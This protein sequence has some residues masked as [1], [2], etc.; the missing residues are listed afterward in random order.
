M[1]TTWT[2]RVAAPF[3]IAA[4][5]VACS[6]EE[7]KR[8][9][10]QNAADSKYH[11]VSLKGCVEEAPGSK[12]FVLRQVQIEPV[13]MQRPDAPGA[14]GLTVTDGSWVRLRDESD[15]L[16]PHLGKIVSVSGTIIDDGRNTIGT[17][18]KATDPDETEPPV[19]KSRAAKD[20]HHASKVTKEAGPIGRVSQS[21]GSVPE[22]S[23]DRVTA[24]GEACKNAAPKAVQR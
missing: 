22:M 14:H 13:S 16:K 21:N 3:A 20:E 2:V 17:S 12:Q 24:T 9:A 15:Q 23:V 18:G 11:M 1:R 10:Q 5:V 19:D 7:D 8:A 4:M 6:Q